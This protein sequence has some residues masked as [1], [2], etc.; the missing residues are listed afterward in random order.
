MTIFYL[1]L[2]VDI[3]SRRFVGFVVRE[4]ESMIASSAL[5]RAT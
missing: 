2:I 5:I 1:Y 3:W 4:E